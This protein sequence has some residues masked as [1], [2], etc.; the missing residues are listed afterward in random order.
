MHANKTTRIQ[1]TNYKLLCLF[2]LFL[3]ALCLLQQQ[4]KTTNSLNAGGCWLK[5][6]QKPHFIVM[7]IV[8]GIVVACGGGLWLSHIHSTVT[9]ASIVLWL[10]VLA[11][12]LAINLASSSRATGSGIRGMLFMLRALGVL[13]SATGAR[14]IWWA[15]PSCK[16]SD[17]ASSKQANSHK[18]LFFSIF[19]ANQPEK[20]TFLTNSHTHTNKQTNELPRLI[21]SFLLP[22]ATQTHTQT[23]TYKYR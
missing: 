13:C 14:A 17:A 19:E 10:K 8:I 18:I 9:L 3:Y 12:R 15:L 7:L 1:V 5:T 11:S 22:I 20:H 4:H 2:Y 6:K 21:L 16:V 23:H